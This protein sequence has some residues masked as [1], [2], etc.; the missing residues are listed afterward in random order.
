M[1]HAYVKGY[2]RYHL[3]FYKTAYATKIWAKKNGIVNFGTFLIS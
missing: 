3:D 2:I 1:P